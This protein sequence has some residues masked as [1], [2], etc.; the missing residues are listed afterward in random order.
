MFRFINRRFALGWAGA[1][2]AV[3]I[4]AGLSAGATET[5]ETAAEVK[6][7]AATDVAAE[8]DRLLSGQLEK[9][10]TSLADSTSDEDFL[11]RAT[12]DLAGTLPSPAEITLFS[13][14][15]DSNKR[16]KLVDQLLSE[17]DFAQNWSLYWRD[18]IFSRA[19]DMRARLA[20]PA[21]EQWMT[22]QLQQNRK[23]DEIVTELITATGDVREV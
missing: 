21:F 17:G 20:Q 9:S 1:G 3:A 23:W 19:T 4:I 2:L 22:R 10:G 8:I 5:G 16:A 14:N 6:S 13:L 15:P 18:V 7:T 12:L 11:R